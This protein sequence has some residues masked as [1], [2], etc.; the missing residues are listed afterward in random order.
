MLIWGDR[1]KPSLRIRLLGYGY[2]VYYAGCVGLFRPSVRAPRDILPADRRLYYSPHSDLI[3]GVFAAGSFRHCAWIND[4]T[5]GGYAGA[6][7][8]LASGID[9]FRIGRGGPRSPYEQVRDFL[10]Q[11]PGPV[12]IFTDGGRRDGR[13]RRSLVGLARESKRDAV[14]LRIRADRALEFQGQLVPRPF[15]AVR[16]RAG[17]PVTYEALAAP[18]LSVDRARQRLQDALD[19]L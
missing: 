5:L 8:A 19:A 12:G 11:H 6:L 15:S 3:P 13:V 4:N 14:P 16:L 7:P 17:S 2:G 18:G 10:V 1:I 9:V